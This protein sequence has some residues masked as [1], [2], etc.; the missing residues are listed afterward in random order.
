MTEG[1]KEAVPGSSHI[2]TIKEQAGGSR[3]T[4]KTA[5]ICG[6]SGS[7]QQSEFLSQHH[8]RN[9]TLHG[10]VSATRFRIS[11]RCQIGTLIGFP[12]RSHHTLNKARFAF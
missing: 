8:K 11:R 6:R 12:A 7:N 4:R 9:L 5:A 10:E 1:D 3:S 2:I